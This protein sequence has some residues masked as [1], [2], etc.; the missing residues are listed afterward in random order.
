M[1]AELKFERENRDGV[2]VVGTY[3]IDASRRLG[4]EVEAECGRLGLCDTCAVKV[5]GGA[6]C[7]TDLTKAEKEKLSE[8]RRAAGERLS[9]QAKIAKEGEISILTFEK[10]KEEKPTEEQKKEEFRKE[11]EALPLEKKIARLVE[12][13]AVA[14]GETFSFV[15]NSPYTIIGKVMD[16]MAEFG[17]KLDRE[18]KK[19]ARPAEHHEESANGAES[20]ATADTENHSKDEDEKTG[21]EPEAGAETD[22][23]NS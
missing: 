17:I 20:R 13:E 11:F 12:L 22:T 5:T 19:A 1:E 21:A 14:L 7:L 8:E 4:V 6:D 23:K 2:A 16:L 15:M 9:C 10:K 3:L 18:T